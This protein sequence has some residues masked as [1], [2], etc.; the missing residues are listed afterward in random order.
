MRKKL[1]AFDVDGT[2][3]DRKN[4]VVPD[5]ALNT[6]RH[7]REQGHIVGVATGR[8]QTQ[9][10]KAIDPNE[11]DF[12]IICNGGYLEIKGKHVYDI[13]FSKEKKNTLCDLLDSLGYEYGITTEHHLYAVN[14]DSYGVRKIVEDYDVITPER[15]SNLRDLPIY[16]FTIY[17]ED[18]TREAINHIEGEFIIHSF[19]GFGYDIVVPEINKGIMLHEVAKIFQMDIK[20]TIAFGDADNDQMFLKE[21]GI[22]VA[23]GNGSEGTKKNADFVTSESYNNGIYNGVKKLGYIK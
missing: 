12:C 11:F 16:Q 2:L 22:G 13:Q 14:P 9:L 23:M 21:A 10:E 18:S 20:D 4:N 6:V 17:E 5:S 3:L 1:F 7:L 19:D 8:N 15:K